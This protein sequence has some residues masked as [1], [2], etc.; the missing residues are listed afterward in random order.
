MKIDIVTIFPEYFAPLDISLLGKARRAGLLDVRV[1]DL[2]EWTHDRHRTVDDTPYGGGPGMV[3]K[4][5]PWGEAL[6]ALVPP[7]PSDGLGNAGAPADAAVPASPGAPERAESGPAPG[8]VP[9]LI[10]PTPSGRPF[11][12][13]DAV[14]YAA[15]PRLLFACGRYEGIDSRVA[16]EAR[17]RMPVDE[18]SLG[19]FVLAGGE[20]AVLV[21]IEA[22]GRLL[23]GVLGNA[24][25][26]ADDSFA[27]GA[28]E[29]LLEGPVYTK[30]PVWRDRPVP[31]V[32]LSGHHGAIARWRRD[33]ALR[34]TARHRPELLRRFAPDDLDARDREVLRDAGF[35]VDSEGVAD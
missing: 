16:E 24:D 22:I 6:D 26:V 33:E 14:R 19:D 35:P 12:Q 5:G 10:I 8:A 20:V 13:A 11:T 31:D 25:S 15:E 30:P 18:V 2:R 28:M 17:T 34:R 21:M 27:P 4:P 7:P 32:L 9:R 1:H 23:P 3:M 29:S